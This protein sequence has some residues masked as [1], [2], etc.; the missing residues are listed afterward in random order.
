MKF[1]LYKHYTI[2]DIQDY[3]ENNDFDI[4][5]LGHKIIGKHII[6]LESQLNGEGYTFLLTGTLIGYVYKLVWS[7]E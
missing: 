6:I 2:L 5:E 1:K 7:G 3:A 4:S